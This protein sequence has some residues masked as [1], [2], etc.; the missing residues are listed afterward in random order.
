MAGTAAAARLAPTLCLP[1]SAR[2]RFA[3]ILGFRSG[4][5]SP[6]LRPLPPR[7]RRQQPA[8]T[9][10][11]GPARCG[12]PASTLCVAVARF[13][14]APPHLCYRSLL[15]GPGADESHQLG[16][17]G[18][19]HG[20][21][22]LPARR[23]ALRGEL[24]GGLVTGFAHPT[25]P[26]RAPHPRP[27]NPARSSPAAPRSVAGAPCSATCWRCWY[28]WYSTDCAA[29]ACRRPSNP[30]PPRRHSPFP[31]QGPRGDQRRPETEDQ[32]EP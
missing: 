11:V 5:T 15:A 24:L 30:V 12:C 29:L 16:Q 21:R 31:A 27:A 32:E 10:P 8:A 14:L 7:A 17:R 13:Y 20:H 3:G 1:S 25:L 19:L 6:R 4:A 22:G 26:R 2:W 9:P 18:A 28:C 23:Q